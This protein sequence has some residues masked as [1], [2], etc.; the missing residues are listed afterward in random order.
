MKPVAFTLTAP[1]NLATASQAY[2][3]TEGARLIAGGQSL[4]PMLN[5]RVAQPKSL[6]RINSI[7][8]IH[9]VAE[10]ATHIFIGACVTHASIADGLAPDIGGGILPSIAE[11]IAYRA[12]RNRG[13]IGG[14]ICHADPAADWV[15]T[16][17][18]LGADAIIFRPNQQA[19]RLVPLRHFIAGAFRTSLELGEILQAIRIPKTTPTSRWGYF[20]ACRKPGEFAHAMA[21]VLE[22]PARGFRR[23]AIGAMGGPPLVF[24]GDL[25]SPESLA[26]NFRAHAGELDEIAQHMHLIAIKRAFERVAA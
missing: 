14:S 6:I 5:L 22:D 2:A 18:A 9:G 3:T 20:K 1:A 13:T 17:I 7:P 21:A 16:L 12:V 23:I 19:S 10:T 11:N 8:E 26:K 24:E 4:G 25:A 15:C